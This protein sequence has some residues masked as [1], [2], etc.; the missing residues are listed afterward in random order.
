MPRSTCCDVLGDAVTPAW[1]NVSWLKSR[2]F[3]GSSRIWLWSTSAV[4]DAC[5]VWTSVLSAVTTT[6]SDMPPIAISTL[7]TSAWPTD[8]ATLSYSAVRKPDSSTVTSYLPGASPSARYRPS[9]SVVIVR[10]FPVS[11][12]LIAT[13][14]PGSA[15][16]EESTI[17]PEIDPVVPCAATSAK[18]TDSVT[19][20]TAISLSTAATWDVCIA[21]LRSREVPGF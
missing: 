15:L 7:R 19:A 4:S 21:L 13:V 3:S 12:S 18:F 2:P 1:S 5:F 17:N 10:V 9:S 20:A 8:T 16:F 6:R 11:T 14:A